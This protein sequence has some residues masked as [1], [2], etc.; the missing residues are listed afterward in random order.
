M[1]ILICGMAL[2][3]GVLAWP[4]L[5]TNL[6]APVTLVVWLL[7]RVLVLSVHQSVYWTALVCA[8]PILLVAMLRRR[9]G[10][11]AWPAP[12]ART[13]RAHPVDTWRY[14]V[15]QTAGGERTPPAIGWNGFVQLAVSL[16]ALE[17]RVP[18]DYLLHDA[19][20]TGQVPL[21]TEVHAFLFPAPDPRPRGRA[22]RLGRWLAEAPRGA[23]RRLSGR[24]R[25]ERLRSMSLLLSFLEES[26][27]M[28]SH[29]DPGDH[30][31]R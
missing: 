23:L 17:L 31:N 15:D 2:A 8:V 12:A 14:L 6:V 19:L 27:E 22:A 5:R 1:K 30:A 13:A 21:P 7:L 28:T 9:S 26:L 3:I 10:P 11:G 20:R 16:R 18:P 25:S 24:D 29:D 4:W